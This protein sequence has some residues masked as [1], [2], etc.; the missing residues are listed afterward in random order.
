MKFLKNWTIDLAKLPAYSCFKGV[1]NVELDYNL[2]QLCYES[3]NE[4]FTE[5]RK[6]LLL[7]I[8]QNIDKRTNI[9]KV[10]H[11][12]RYGLGRFYAD[13]SISPIC[14][15]RHIKHTL[16]HYLDWIDIDMVKGH[17]TIL[18]CIAKNNNI[19]LPAF[20]EYLDNPQI[21]FKELIDYYS[22]EN[23]TPL[24]EDNVKD[25]F[26]ISIYGGNHNTWLGQMEDQNVS[27]KTN[28]PHPFV[29]KFS[30]DCKDLKDLIYLNNAE[31]I[32]RVKGDITDENKIKRRVM[33]YFCG[34]IENEILSIAYKYLIKNNVIKSK[35]NVL[36]E[37][38]GLCFKRPNKEIGELIYLVDEMNKMILKETNLAIKMTIKNYKP[39]YIHN[40]IIEIRLSQNKEEQSIDEDCEIQNETNECDDIYDKVFCDDD[41]ECAE[42]MIELLGNK[43]IYTNKVIFFKNGNIWT[44]DIL[45]IENM[46]ITF[47]MKNSPWKMSMF[48][49]RLGYTNLN[50]VKSVIKTI[51]AYICQ[52]DDNTIYNKFHSTTKGR[53]AFNDGVLCALTNK[54]YTWKEIDFEYYTT[55]CINRN[56]GHYLINPNW[57]VMEEIKNTIFEPLFSKD[58]ELALNFISRALFGHTEDKNFA[59]YVGNRNS[60]KGVSYELMKNSCGDYVGSFKVDNLLVQREGNGKETARDLYWLL[61]LEFMRLAIA[62]ETPEDSQKYKISAPLQ[63]K[64]CSGGDTQIARRNYDKRDTHFK[65]DATPL[66]MGNGYLECSTTDMNEHRFQFSSL[67]QFK[68][69]EQIDE[70]KKLNLPENVIDERFGIID[71]S[72]KEKCQSEEWCNG[73][74]LLI[75]RFYKTEPLTVHLNKDA[76]NENEKPLI[77][78]LFDKFEITNNEK[79]IILACDVEIYFG[80][81][82][83]KLAAELKALGIVR[84]E[85][86]VRGPFRAKVCYFGIKTKDEVEEEND[87]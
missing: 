71:Y 76:E 67:I 50:S 54:F 16:F 9:L 20:K 13:N 70:L 18:Y 53:L 46:L 1:F 36:L 4:S 63:K 75:M 2:L 29:N 15:S 38:D 85:C 69:Q 30:S 87:D 81:E 58:C 33:S 37:Y 47:I 26:N 32:N 25:I 24:T 73:F 7:P 66:I 31:L 10:K 74:I 17:P 44:N 65:V 55:V 84:K 34:A 72:L 61:E 68:K 11:S 83:K 41:K 64:L 45:L 23:E 51:F 56:F 8:L 77:C 19:E 52:S 22:V 78:R 40:D 3:D 21:K 57:D 12:P 28:I 80:D 86:K 35:E 49:P 6:A 27:I 39:L 48:G 60:G 42:Y 5:N 43:L 82:K 14:V 59:T 62:Q 79:D